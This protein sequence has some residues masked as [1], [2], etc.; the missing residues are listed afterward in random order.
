MT[1]LRKIV[2]S[3]E[4]PPIPIRSMDW[5]AYFDG[6][7][8]GPQGWG[9]TKEAAIADLIENAWTTMVDPIAPRHREGA[10]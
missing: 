1:V 2:T 7:E 5:L 9:P 4:Y 6:D 10:A 8:E 3:H